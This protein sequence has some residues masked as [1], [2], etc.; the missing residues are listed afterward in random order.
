MKLICLNTWGG[1]LKDEL[2]EFITKQSADTDIFCLQEV[3]DNVVNPRKIL[4]NI[5]CNLFDDLTD[6][7]PDFKGF[8]ALQ[9]D[10]D[11]GLAIFV[12]N[13]IKISKTDDIFVF[14]SKNAMLNDDS[15]TIG[16]NIQY[17]QFKENGQDYTVINFHG[18]WTPDGKTDNHDRIKQ[19]QE[20]M[21][22]IYSTA[23]E[24]IVLCGDFNLGPTTKSIAII[25]DG[26][27]NLIKEH[28]ID[29]TRSDYYKKSDK[30]ADYVFVS[31]AINISK[32][33]VL[34][35]QASDHL[36]MLAEFN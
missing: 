20:I 25:E 27:R 32:F 1:I 16:S 3:Y 9:Q 34:H 28:N 33:K 24:K 14:L 36:P 6:W 17:I 4:G 12:K 22:F 26:M 21:K 31:D 15:A 13:T 29:T 8:Y 30:F 23:I 2:C 35:D 5:D 10:N 11:K 7:L 19:S 18:L